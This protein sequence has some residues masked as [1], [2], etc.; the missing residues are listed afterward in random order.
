MTE[1]HFTL[2]KVNGSGSSNIVEVASCLN[3]GTMWSQLL[4]DL[5]AQDLSRIFAQFDLKSLGSGDVASNLRYKHDSE[6]NN[7][8]V[9]NMGDLLSL[10]IPIT[11]TSVSRSERYKSFQFLE[12][13][14]ITVTNCATKEIIKEDTLLLTNFLNHMGVD[15]EKVKQIRES[16]KGARYNSYLADMI[17][18]IY[19]VNFQ[20]HPEMF[21]RVSKKPIVYDTEMMNDTGEP[22]LKSFVKGGKEWK[23]KKGFDYLYFED[24]IQGEG[25]EFNVPKNGSIGKVY[26][27][28]KEL[29]SLE[30]NG[31]KSM[32]REFL[33][34]NGTYNRFSDYWV[35]DVDDGLTILMI[36][37]C[38]RVIGDSVIGDS[39]TSDEHRI[40]TELETIVSEVF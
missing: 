7:Q 39:V 32:V 27:Q 31:M 14:T 10:S 19:M 35:N 36:L 18:F 2:T 26:Y 21:D 34:T 4:D 22:F 17:S 1:P 16:T 29:L 28:L 20:Y 15:G 30:E 11:I 12:N 40:R 38:F 25:N 33:S 5:K 8:V 23:P 9:K 3:F 24:C 6:I 13:G 37:N